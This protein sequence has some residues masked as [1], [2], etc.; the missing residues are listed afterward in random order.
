MRDIVSIHARSAATKT[1]RR[2]FLFVKRVLDVVFSALLMVLLF[3][4]F[5]VV[6]LVATYDTAGSPFFVQTRM[7][8]GGKPFRMIKFRTMSKSA[9]ENVATAD[10]ENADS[11]ISP[12]GH[13]LRKFSLDELPQL[14]NVFKGEM[15]FIG[16]RPVVLSEEELLAMRNLHGAD[17]VRPGITGF[18]QVRGRDNLPIVQKAFLDGYYARH[19]TFVMD[20]KILWR[21]VLYVLRAEGVVDGTAGSTAD[22]KTRTA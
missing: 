13:I 11:F 9:P 18:A 10:L 17:E 20:M 1:P 16:P 19:V 7:G 12:I 21:T 4:V 14:W 15:S 3:P 5:V 6:T 8:R 2:S 22:K